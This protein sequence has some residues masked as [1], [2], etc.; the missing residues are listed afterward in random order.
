MP[1]DPLNDPLLR[2]PRSHAPTIAGMTEAANTATPEQLADFVDAIGAGGGGGGGGHQPTDLGATA[3][4]TGVTVTSSTGADA[5]LPLATAA[6]A[7][8][9]APAQHAKLAD[10]PTAA[11]LATDQAAQDLA[12]SGK[13]DASHTHTPAAIG[14]ATTAQGAKAD[15]ALQP[16][17]LPVG[18]TLPAAQIS[19]A[20]TTGRALLTAADAAAQRTALA[21]GN[22]SN[23]A[24]A[25][26]PVSTA[27][28]LAIAA[29]TTADAI[30]DTLEAAATGAPADLARIK[31]SVSGD[32]EVYCRT[33][34][35]LLAAIEQSK[36]GPILAILAP[37][38]FVMPAA[39]VD[40]EGVTRL[41]I[42]CPTRGAV[43]TR[44][45]HVFSPVELFSTPANSAIGFGKILVIGV[46]FAG[47]WRRTADYLSSF[48]A[49]YAVCAAAFRLYGA[50]TSEFRMEDCELNGLRDLPVVIFHSAYVHLLRSKI[51]RCRDF[52]TV[53]CARV[54]IDKNEAWFSQDNGFSVSRRCRDVTITN[55]Y[56]FGALAAYWVAGWN[57]GVVGYQHAPRQVYVVDNIA[58][59]CSVGVWADGGIQ[60]YRI[61]GNI[62]RN[63]GFV[64]N[65]GNPADTLGAPLFADTVLASDVASGATSVTVG[66]AA[67]I[68]VGGY[69]AVVQGA[70]NQTHV[71]KVDA[72]AGNVVSF[73]EPIP[74]P[75]LAAPAVRVVWATWLDASGTGQ[76]ILVT[77]DT[78]ITP[79]TKNQNGFVHDNEIYGFRV[80]GVEVL[81]PRNVSVDNN[82][83][84]RPMY[85]GTGSELFGIK[86]GDGNTTPTIADRVRV[87]DNVVDMT[88]PAG[89]LLAR[90]RNAINYGTSA[91]AAHRR[92]QI[93]LDRNWVEG[94][95][96]GREVVAPSNSDGPAE[97]VFFD[98]RGIKRAAP[99]I[100]PV[101]ATTGA[102]ALYD[103]GRGATVSNGDILADNQLLGTLVGTSTGAKIVKSGDGVVAHDI[104]NR[105]LRLS[106]G[107]GFA[108]VDLMSSLGIGSGNRNYL[109]VFWAR[110]ET[111]GPSTTSGDEGNAILSYS[112]PGPVRAL[113]WRVHEQQPSPGVMNL[114]IFQDGLGQS[115][116]PVA[117]S[118]GSVYGIHQCAVS[119]QVSGATAVLKVFVDG[120]QVASETR[121]DIAYTNVAGATL[122]LGCGA[123]AA[124]AGTGVIR[125]GM[126]LYRLYAEDLAASAR[127]PATVVATDYAFMA[128]FL[129]GH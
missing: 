123:G 22:V 44:A 108:Y 38:E 34:A 100:D 91:S 29:A 109:I 103:F 61:R 90:G 117:I 42:S 7:G 80:S 101:P 57:D 14:A 37:V 83:V 111:L 8:L 12:I 113:Q 107:T 69:I 49:N 78:S 98:T 116:Q 10:L 66:D 115:P 81:F 17:V 65:S 51:I 89:L 56:V 86:I 23:T 53:N 48:G 19:D 58:D 35:D 67:L 60:S 28:A 50:E 127:D 85:T 18:T 1:L 25:D 11:A 40:L 46:K 94:V 6:N 120:A 41:T 102:L 112:G 2:A 72:L 105:C 118:A 33:T 13:A 9:M 4:P 5:L 122:K 55:N 77:G 20:T 16:G 26:K 21:L 71:R 62:L 15:T 45:T 129:S 75:I 95:L 30:A 59:C 68:T 110:M 70:E 79:A 52:G 124:A 64:A 24:D 97:N 87:Y 76:G 27:Q 93:V 36:L 99:I 125:P 43:I 74:E 104:T 63:N 54:I 126:R 88:P 39:P 96:E 32:G 128:P 73:L 84:S 121:A 82:I 119:W 92:H 114:S 31:S 106:A 47:R 3:T